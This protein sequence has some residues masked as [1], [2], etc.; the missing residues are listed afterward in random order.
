[1]HNISSKLVSVEHYSVF[2]GV[3]HSVSLAGS[4]L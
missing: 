1:M 3:F 4:A 2:H